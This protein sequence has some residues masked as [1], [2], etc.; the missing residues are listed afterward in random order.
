[1]LAKGFRATTD[2]TEISACDVAVI[3]VPTPLSADGGPD[4]GAVEAATRTVARN[5]YCRKRS[6]SHMVRKTLVS[7]ALVAMVA[8]CSSG[9]RSTAPSASWGSTAASDPGS[10]RSFTK[11]VS[12]LRR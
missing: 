5:A 9:V 10:S 6:G 12:P 1:M 7:F 2:E 3:C 11:P 4:L 8:A